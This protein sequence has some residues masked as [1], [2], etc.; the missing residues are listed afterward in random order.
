MEWAQTYFFFDRNFS[1]P[2]K[3]YSFP[4]SVSL[5]SVSAFGKWI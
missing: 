4:K 2:H 1:N 5:G 3:I